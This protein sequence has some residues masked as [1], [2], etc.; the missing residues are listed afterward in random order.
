MKSFLVLSLALAAGLSTPA[1]VAAREVAYHFAP[2]AQH[3][4][5][6]VDWKGDDRARVVT[7]LG[8]SGASVAP[9]GGGKLLSF[10]A[11]LSVD[12]PDQ[13]D[14]CGEL[15]TLRS[16]HAQLMVR[17]LSARS[18]A[19]VDI[20]HTVHLGGCQDGLTEPF[21]S[22]DDPGFEHVATPMAKRPSMGDVVAGAQFA[23]FSE[24]PYLTDVFLPADVATLQAGGTIRF[25]GSGH[26]FPAALDADQ[27]LV[28][29]LPGGPRAYTRLVVDAKTGAETWLHAERVG[30]KPQRVLETLVVKPAAGA[31]FG[32]VAQASR[33][34]EWGLFK[35]TEIT[36][37][38]WLYRDMT[39]ERVQ[40]D[41]DGDFRLPINAWR[42]EGADIVQVRE[43]PGLLR[44]RRWVPL[45]N[46]GK[47]RW[48]MESEW[49]TFD[50]GE[51][52]LLIQPRV[53]L[54][55][56]LGKAIKPL[57]VPAALLRAAPAQWARSGAPMQAV[58]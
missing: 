40:H 45:R 25:E 50:G 12:Y 22:P 2:M 33:M 48:V 6:L 55:T 17:E 53:A 28:V 5:Y 37:E 52:E 16:T 57:Q 38:T 13:Y 21:G 39:G 11:P 30:G 32:S 41:P 58:R 44:E 26:V 7:Q 3:S 19:L 47:H 9:H 29:Q 49:W 51:P 14:E 31:G 43:Q 54:F 42:F 1:G 56:D 24:Q 18:A 20:G 46:E 36:G 27:W 8:A 23:G 10:D 15:F 4:A 35:G 34:W